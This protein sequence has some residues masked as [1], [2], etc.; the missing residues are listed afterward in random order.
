MRFAGGAIEAQAA[1]F[2]ESKIQWGQRALVLDA[3]LRSVVQQVLDHNTDT[4][5]TGVA[6]DP[7]G[8][9]YLTGFGMDPQIPTPA[10]AFQ[11]LG[12]NNQSNGGIVYRGFVAKFSP[13]TG[14]GAGAS[15]LYGTY[16]GG[17]ALNESN[18]EQVSGMLSAHQGNA[19]ITGYT[20]SYDFPV[21]PGANVTDECGPTTYA[22]GS[23]F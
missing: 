20:Q 19:Y 3:G 16:L 23:V 10:G 9:F 11:R 15:L 22:R 5:E 17:T 21:T 7:S 18:G 14:T 8:N 6:V 12:S 1:G 2:A 13:V 4:L